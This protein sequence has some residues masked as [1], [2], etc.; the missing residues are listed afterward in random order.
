MKKKYALSG[1]GKVLCFMKH[2]LFIFSLLCSTALTVLAG[3]A[4]GQEPL[5]KQVTI[6]L[7]D[8]L[9]GSALEKI[10]RASGVRFTYNG[11][12]AGSPARVSVSA[13][14]SRLKDVLNKCFDGH[15]I[16]Y[17]V[18]GDEIVVQYDA[19]AS[20]TSAPCWPTRAWPCRPGWLGGA[21]RVPGTGCW[22][23]Y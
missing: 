18:L 19:P 2:G 10:S 21:N 11:K 15:P 8:E 12:V 23:R 3:H 20:S 7:K 16:S 14:N 6:T 4:K 5:D 13:K 17:K 22:R 1:K 9:L